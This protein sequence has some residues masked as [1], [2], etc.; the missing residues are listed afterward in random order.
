MEQRLAVAIAAELADPKLCIP[1][2]Q[3]LLESLRGVGVDPAREALWIDPQHRVLVAQL[4]R[5]LR[6]PRELGA[7]AIGEER[8]DVGERVGA[9]LAGHLQRESHAGARA[10]EALPRL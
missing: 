10:R 5:V 6:Q 7:L 2:D 3:E 9:A 1:I 4:G 8:A